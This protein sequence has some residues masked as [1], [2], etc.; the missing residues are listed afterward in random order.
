[1]FSL[2]PSLSESGGGSKMNLV[3][4]SRPSRP[5]RSLPSM[6]IGLVG[7]L[8]GVVDAGR[9]ARAC[10][11]RIT[12]QVG[13]VDLA[14]LVKILRRVCC[15]VLVRHPR[16]MMAQQAARFRGGRMEKVDSRQRLR[17]ELLKWFVAENIRLIASAH[18][19]WQVGRRLSYTITNKPLS[20]NGTAVTT[21][22]CCVARGVISAK[23]QAGAGMPLL[24]IIKTSQVSS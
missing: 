11:R 16:A 13:L 21:S 2:P 1:M 18:L 5:S 10:Q 8:V 7:H 23:R 9:D 19:T 20:N 22:R 3:R 12:M 4:S 17:T 15:S 24:V 6:T 14:S